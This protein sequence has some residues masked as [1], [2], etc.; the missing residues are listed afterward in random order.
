MSTFSVCVA[1]TLSQLSENLVKISRSKMLMIMI[2]CHTVGRQ[3]LSCLLTQPK[4]TFEIRSGLRLRRW[5]LVEVKLTSG[6]STANQIWGW[7]M[8]RISSLGTHRQTTCSLCR[9]P[10]Q[11][12]KSVIFTCRI[13]LDV[14]INVTI[15]ISN[16]SHD[17]SFLLIILHQSTKE[18]HTS[19]LHQAFGHVSTRRTHSTQPGSQWC[20]A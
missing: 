3:G 4:E 19:A 16:L 14:S 5:E 1:D 11:A 17:R 13:F 15:R 18:I 10:T 6:Y 12:A 8:A 9:R 7:Y 2:G 20:Y